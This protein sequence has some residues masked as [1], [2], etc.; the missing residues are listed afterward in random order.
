M[1]NGG[2]GALRRPEAAAPP[3][4]PMRKDGTDTMGTMDAVS[5]KNFLA[6]AAAAMGLAAVGATA[7]AAHAGQAKADEAQATGVEAGSGRTWADESDVVVVGAGFGGMVAAARALE[8]GASVTILEASVRTGGTALLCSGILGFGGAE[9]AVDTLSSSAPMADKSLLQT[10]VD[11]WPELTQWLVDA[12][13]PIA[14]V[15]GNFKFGGEDA[16]APDGNVAMADWFAQHLEESGATIVYGARAKELVIENGAIAGVKAAVDGG[17]AFYKADAVVLA[18]GGFMGDDAKKE[19]FMGV[20][21]DQLANRG[22]P[23]NVGDGMEMGL[24]AGAALSKGLSTFYGYHLPWPRTIVSTVEE[25]DASVGDVEWLAAQ[26]GIM[27]NIQGWSNACCVVNQEGKRF[28]DETQRDNIVSESTAR[29]KFARSYVV[30][31]Q[32]VRDTFVGSSK[33]LGKE[34]VDV[35]VESGAELIQADTL[36]GLADALWTKYRVAPG[37]LLRTVTE[38]NEACEAGAAAELDVPKSDAEKA[39][40]LTTAPFYAIAAVPG[41]SMCYGGLKIDGASRVIGTDQRVIPGLYALPGVGG[42]VTYY[43]SVGVLASICTFAWA[44]GADAAE[45]A[46]R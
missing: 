4:F 39:V 45:T 21:A 30:F 9:I 29:Q 38:Y 34:K 33:R 42:G 1:H 35:L 43:D 15:G 10:Y 23:H 36:E 11:A 31:D 14:E 37:A 13:A 6:T 41:V 44:A 5:R 20:F 27:S 17:D 7:G 3:G 2:I 18:C 40:A 19:V 32:N 12:D 16:T 8:C 22:N 28:D 24:Q 26:Q 46:T 25:W